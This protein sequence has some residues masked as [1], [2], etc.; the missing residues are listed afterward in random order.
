MTIV[1]INW[2]KWKFLIQKGQ[3]PPP[4]KLATTAMNIFIF[5][6]K[7]QKYLDEKEIEYT[8]KK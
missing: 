3:T 4:C 6:E 7:L 8:L 1:V 2:M 5:N